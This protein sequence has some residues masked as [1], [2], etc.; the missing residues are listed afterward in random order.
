MSAHRFFLEGDLPP[1]DA[2]GGVRLPLD[3]EDLH[4]AVS[5]LRL[6]RGEE[7]EVVEPGGRVWRALVGEVMPK[8]L[9]AVL[10][11]Q[12]LAEERSGPAVTLVQGVAK[13]EKM[14]SIVRQT[15]EVGVTRIVPVLTDR[16]VVKLDAGKAAN[17]GER[18][19]R[20]ARSAAGQAHRAQVPRVDDPA[21]LEAAS[22]SLREADAVVVLWEEEL[23]SRTLGSVLSP[24]RGDRDAHVAL[25]VGPE[26][27]LSAAEVE[28]LRAMGAVT[29]SLSR[30]I[31]RTET[32]AVVAVTLAIRELDAAPEAT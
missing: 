26:G 5:V 4:H 16:V 9:T 21:P 3:P 11:D 17:R 8:E 19:R 6:R 30:N 28:R 31:L 20:I 27:G 23:P 12:P 14:D 13:G 22:S 7:I 25:V 15:V 24:L 32:A 29:A 2:E 1:A 10:A 18:W